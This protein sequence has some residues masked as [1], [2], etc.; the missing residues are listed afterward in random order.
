MKLHALPL[1]PSSAHCAEA[2]AA[3]Q[4]LQPDGGEQGGGLEGG[5][6]AIG[7]PGLAAFLLHARD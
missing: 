6:G 1:Q 2:K 5:G 3:G 4:E 7:A